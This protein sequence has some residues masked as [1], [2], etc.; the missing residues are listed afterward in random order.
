MSERTS[1][2]EI[3][4]RTESLKAA[5]DALEPARRA[6]FDSALELSWIYHDNALEGLV[7]HY[8]EMK[9]GVDPRILSDSTLIP[10][11]DDIV[12][13]KAAIDLIREMAAK[14]RTQLGFDLNVIKQIHDTVTVDDD[15]KQLLYRKENPLHRLYFHEIAPPDKISYKLRKLAEWAASPEFRKMHPI[16]RAASAHLRLISIYPWLKNSGKT[17]RLL[18]NLLLMRDGYLPAIIHAVERQRYYEVLRADLSELTR[19]V[20]EAIENSIESALRFLGLVAAPGGKLAPAPA[21]K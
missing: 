3:D 21:E 13:H 1:F 11:Y 16:H 14:R 2:Y 20:V 18:M 15:G 4:A 6:Q 19:L 17:S 9:A 5:L 8:H 12:Y 10:S 7:L